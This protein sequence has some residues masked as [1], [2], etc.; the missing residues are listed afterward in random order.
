MSSVI[1]STKLVTVLY[2]SYGV[3]RNTEP[4]HLNTVTMGR[5][6]LLGEPPDSNSGG[7]AGRD[8]SSAQVGNPNS[9][10]HLFPLVNLLLRLQNLSFKQFC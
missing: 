1:I 10:I 3:H 2:V 4:N 8:V 7:E 9:L 5:Y 6:V